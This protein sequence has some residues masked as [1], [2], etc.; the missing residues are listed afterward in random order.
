M[1]DFDDILKPKDV[2]RILKVTEQTLVNWDKR[3]ILVSGRT[4]T[5]KRFYTREQIYNFL[6]KTHENDKLK[7]IYARVSGPD[8]REHL[9]NQ[10]K[11]IKNYCA[12]NNIE[13]DEIISDVGSGLNYERPNWNSLLKEVEDFHISDIYVTYKDRFIRFGFDWFN[14]F[15]KLHGCTIHV[16]NQEEEKTDEE[17]MM[18]DLISIIHVFSSKIYGLR[19]YK[20]KK[21]LIGGGPNN[22][23]AKDSPLS[24]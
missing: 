20:T 2:K 6:N 14:S 4:P 16:I 9:K 21:D 3:G 18:D 8:Q 10:I 23:I 17:E 15:C 24:E 12:S 5:N 1:K 22:D 7:V 19:K 13:I 11:S